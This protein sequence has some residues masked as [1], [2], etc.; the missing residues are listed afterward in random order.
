M[1]KFIFIPVVNN[2]DLLKKAVQSI[3]ESLYTECIIFNNSE[4]QIPLDIYANTKFKV[5]NPKNR[6]TFMQT[7]NIMRQ[8]A[9]NNNFDYYIWMHNDAEILNNIDRDIIDFTET[10][11]E[12]WGVIFTNYDVFSVFNTECVKNIGLWGD[13]SWPE[14]QSGYYQD[15][16]YYRRIKLSD[17]KIKQFLT[18]EEVL[19]GNSILAPERA[20]A[21]LFSNVSH[22]GKNTLS[23]K[24]EKNIWAKQNYLILS[25][26]KKKW[27][28]GPGDEK[29]K[30]PFGNTYGFFV[31]DII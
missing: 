28:G 7:Q 13:I 2:F 5:W 17:Y 19:K 10:C 11:N 1:K 26:Y 31:D 6:F 25:H 8:Y 16:D 4:K 24:E 27:G 9:I 29:F 15:Y 20:A 18:K 14:Q 23:D 3:D 21:N 22:I 30:T 12:K